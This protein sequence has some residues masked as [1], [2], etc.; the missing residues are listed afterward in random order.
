MKLIEKSTSWMQTRIAANGCP[1][2]YS[3]LYSS[4][5]PLLWIYPNP[6][7]VGSLIINYNPNFNLYSPSS[8]NAGD[9]GSFINDS[10]S[11]NTTLPTQYD[12]LLLLG[13]LKWLF[14]DME[15]DY[16]KESMLLLS[17]QYNGET[18]TKYSM[19]GCINKGIS[20]KIRD[21]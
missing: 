18:F 7:N 21:L 19:E 9:F 5:T 20:L 13:M 10:W 3:L 12:K 14:K 17:K 1:V 15:E 16:L 2:H 11:G 6:I 8:V 4:A